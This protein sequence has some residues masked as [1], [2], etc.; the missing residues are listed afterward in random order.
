M[1]A[2]ASVGMR[3]TPTRTTIVMKKTLQQIR[4]EASDSGAPE[5]T[6]NAASGNSYM[7]RTKAGDIEAQ[8]IGM[9]SGSEDS[10]KLAEDEFG[11]DVLVDE[12]GRPVVDRDLAYLPDP[13]Y[14][15]TGHSVFAILWYGGFLAAI[16]FI[17]WTFVTYEPEQ[18]RTV[19]M[20]SSMADS[21]RVPLRLAVSCTTNTSVTVRELYTGG[22]PSTPC[23]AAAA[24]LQNV[25]PAVP[26]NASTKPEIAVSLCYTAEQPYNS[27][28]WFPALPGVAVRFG[29]ISTDDLCSVDVYSALPGASLRPLKRLSVEGNVVKTLFVSFSRK[30]EKETPWFLDRPPTYAL[31]EESLVARYYELD[32]LR[33]TSGSSSVVTVRFQDTA[34][35]VVVYDMRSWVKAGGIFGT[36]WYMI[37]AYAC[38]WAA[39]LLILFCP[40]DLIAEAKA[41]KLDGY[42]SN[43]LSNAWRPTV[44]LWIGGELIKRISHATGP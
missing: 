38:F 4:D 27:N 36:L 30:R 28:D 10:Y 12:Y 32:G 3:M 39:P 15:N 29:N 9:L 8:R 42:T 35:D 1:A 11:M 7:T 40:R 5:P 31:L 34:N 18:N 24:R 16:A 13:R 20:T 44:W 33:V 22:S 2:L 17:T 23:S 41:G 37:S 6:F 25:E 19:L 26:L 43:A 14:N 21:L